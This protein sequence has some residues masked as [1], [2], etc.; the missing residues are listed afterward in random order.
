MDSV[1]HLLREKTGSK[2]GS[3][4]LEFAEHPAFRRQHCHISD[5]I[6]VRN[7][8]DHDFLRS[9]VFAFFLYYVIEIFVDS[10]VDVI[11]LL[12]SGDCDETVC[13]GYEDRKAEHRCG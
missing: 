8:R 13:V 9:F 11:L 10:S 5:R 4:Y 7:Y 2:L 12:Q 3:L 6:S 1:F